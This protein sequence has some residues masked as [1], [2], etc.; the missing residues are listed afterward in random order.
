MKVKATQLGFD[1][2]CLRYPGDVFEV[3]DNQFT[4]V[5]MEKVDTD[6]PTTGIKSPFVGESEKETPAQTVPGKSLMSKIFKPKTQV[7]T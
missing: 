2:W 1:G 4:E 7:K 3:N 6:V 5:W